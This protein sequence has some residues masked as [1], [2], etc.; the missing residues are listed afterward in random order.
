M[1]M[2]RVVAFPC[3]G[4]DTMMGAIAS[5]EGMIPVHGVRITHIRPG[6]G[7]EPV[8]TVL[9]WEKILSSKAG[10]GDNLQLLPGDRIILEEK[11][12]ER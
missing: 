6:A 8:V 12:E 11:E 1:P 5:I 9:D 7:T 3:T 4:N 2:D 10:F